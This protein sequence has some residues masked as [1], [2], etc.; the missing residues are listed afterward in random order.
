MVFLG[1]RGRRDV[2]AARVT[3]PEHPAGDHRTGRPYAGRVVGTAAPPRPPPFIRIGHV[4]F[5]QLDVGE[6]RS[7]SLRRRAGSRV[8]DPY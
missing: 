7:A 1:N 8:N 4:G 3:G 2:N 6:V 5:D